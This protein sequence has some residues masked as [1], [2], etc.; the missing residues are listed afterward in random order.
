[1]W[2]TQAFGLL[3]NQSNWLFSLQVRFTKFLIKLETYLISLIKKMPFLFLFFC[4]CIL[5]FNSGNNETS[6]NR[7]RFSQCLD[8][9]NDSSCNH[10]REFLLSLSLSFYF[11]FRLL[12]AMCI[13]TTFV[14]L[15]IS[16]TATTTM[17][18]PI[19]FAIL[20]VFEDVRTILISLV[21]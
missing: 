6:C 15:W 11:T 5:F 7:Y 14:S 8:S 21:F 9:A 20:K 18:V 3:C 13:V 16:N 17:M 4:D 12:L 1:M 19:N 2:L 10:E